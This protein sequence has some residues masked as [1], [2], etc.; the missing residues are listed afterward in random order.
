MTIGGGTDPRAQL[1]GLL[2]GAAQLGGLHFR[3]VNRMKSH[4]PHCA[5][6]CG[7]CSTH[8][9]R[10]RHQLDKAPG[11]AD[12]RRSGALR[13]PDRAAKIGERQ[14]RFPRSPGQSSSPRPHGSTGDNHFRAA[15]GLG[16]PACAPAASTA[17]ACCVARAG[18][19]WFAL[20]SPCRA[21]ASGPHTFRMHG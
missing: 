19:A 5:H 21:I 7:R 15:P 12:K 1:N 2:N 4:N 17:P 3:Q 10:G 16:S 18:L 8:L 11:A 14:R 20:R 13:G 6:C 9:M